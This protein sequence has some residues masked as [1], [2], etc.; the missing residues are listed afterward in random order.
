MRNLL[1]TIRDI[2]IGGKSAMLLTIIERDGSTP[3]GVGTSMVLSAD[4]AQTGTIGG[5]AVEYQARMD[6][7]KAFDGCGYA[8]REYLLY[9]DEA[10]G[11]GMICGGRVRVLFRCFSGATGT[12][13]VERALTLLAEE[14]EAY[15][16]TPV[17]GEQAGE[18]KALTMAEAAENPE[19]TVYLGEK[20]VLTEGETQWLI[21]PL[22]GAPR[23]IVFGGGHVSQ[24]MVPLLSLIDYRVWVLED[25]EEFAR[26]ALFPTAERILHL[27]FDEAEQALGITSRD[28]VIVLTRGHQ[29]DFRILRWILRTKADY[30]GCIGSKTK[31]KLTRERLLADGFTEAELNRLHSPIGLQIG[32]E[33]PAEIAVSVAAE[34]IQYCASQ[35]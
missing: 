19:I 16:V 12:T 28:H 18:T 9:A 15:L 4:G 17:C 27:P 7:L 22:H 32:A 23:V 26:E 2:L 29:S 1:E 14:R 20:P 5:G 3:R 13:V 30:I 21:E 25:R 34:L 11:V 8:T 31:V 24:K 35:R 10:N 33:T 6:A